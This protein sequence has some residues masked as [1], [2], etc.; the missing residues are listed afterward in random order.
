MLL[1]RPGQ[2]IGRCGWCRRSTR[3]RRSGTGGRGG[4]PAHELLVIAVRRAEPARP[5]PARCWR[6]LVGGRGRR[7]LGARRAGGDRAAGQSHGEAGYHRQ[8]EPGHGSHL[9][10][11]HR[12]SSDAKPARPQ[13]STFSTLAGDASMRHP[14][15]CR[16]GRCGTVRVGWPRQRCKAQFRPRVVWQSSRPGSRKAH[17]AKEVAYARQITR[18]D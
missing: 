15:G 4:K 18:L 16:A 11:G 14:L 8:H 10:I 2:P 6:A 9:T 3:S 12:Q 1:R 7:G 17:R 5:G 13:P